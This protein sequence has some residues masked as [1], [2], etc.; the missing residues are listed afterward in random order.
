MLAHFL[1]HCGESGKIQDGS[2]VIPASEFWL[3][4][5]VSLEE[6][7]EGHTWMCGELGLRILGLRTWF[8]VCNIDEGDFCAH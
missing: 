3:G 8:N 1:G 6:E 4:L 7:G 5:A 2:R